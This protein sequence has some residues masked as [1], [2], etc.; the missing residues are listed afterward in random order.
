[1]SAHIGDDAALYALGALDDAERARVDD[2]VAQ[3]EDCT[4]RLGEAERDAT[5]LIEREMQHVPPATVTPLPQRRAP[6][7]WRAAFA[8]VAAILVLGI[9][10]SLYF[11]QQNRAMH[12]AMHD[13]AAAMQRL[14][15]APFRSADFTGSA[16]GRVMYAKD[17]SWYV[18]VVRGAQHAL[19]VAWPHD[20]TRTMLGSAVPHGDLAMLYLPRSHRMGQLALMDGPRVVAEA[21]LRY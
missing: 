11:W 3:C 1:M 6:T 7:G 13:R 19:Q 9:A 12:L 20:G 17:G 21:Q 5:L 4:R 10:P 15:S 8:A 14:A 18:I 16:R 2:H